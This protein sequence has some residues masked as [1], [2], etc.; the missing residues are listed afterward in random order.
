MAAHSL[1]KRDLKTL[2]RVV[3]NK[4]GFA[5]PSYFFA[6]SRDFLTIRSKQKES[7]QKYNLNRYDIAVIVY[8]Q[9]SANIL[10]IRNPDFLKINP[11]AFQQSRIMAE[12]NS[13][14]GFD[15]FCDR[16]P[17]TPKG[18]LEPVTLVGYGFSNANKTG[19]IGQEKVGTNSINCV[20][21]GLFRIDGSQ[22]A[23]G[24]NMF[25]TSGDS[26]GPLL[27]AGKAIGVF[28]WIHQKGASI[29][30]SFQ[31]EEFDILSYYAVN[32]TELDGN[33]SMTQCARNTGLRTDNNKPLG[34]SHGFKPVTE[35]SNGLTVKVSNTGTCARQLDAESEEIVIH[36]VD[37]I[38]VNDWRGFLIALNGQNINARRKINVKYSAAGDTSNKVGVIDQEI[39]LPT[40]QFGAFAPIKQKTQ[41]F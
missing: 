24:K 13:E 36:S 33:L 37:N 23:G 28:S 5:R 14:Q 39:C 30:S 12:F 2:D 40:I 10:S 31:T 1:G 4:N 17:F 6:Y 9:D 19:S 22:T 8:D 35:D 7:S 15:N 20:R 18:H 27:I 38:S 21:S 11:S 3:G 34:F 26:G 32:C 41:R 16:N 29:Y 25:A